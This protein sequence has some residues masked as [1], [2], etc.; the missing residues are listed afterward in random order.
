MSSI[1]DVGTAVVYAVW[2][3]WYFNIA[4]AAADVHV[5][6]EWRGERKAIE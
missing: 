6:E 4:T 3:L 5:A 1:V 2:C